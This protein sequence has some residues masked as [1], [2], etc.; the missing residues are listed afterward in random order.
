MGKKRISEKYPQNPAL[1]V[2]QSRGGGSVGKKIN[3]KPGG[4]GGLS[5]FWA[6]FFSWPCTEGTKWLPELN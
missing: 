6:S 1:Q 4:G 5:V 3:E 2:T